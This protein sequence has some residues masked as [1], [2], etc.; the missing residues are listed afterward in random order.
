[1]PSYSG[2]WDGIYLT[3]YAAQS[4]TVAIRDEYVMLARLYARRTYGRGS[5]GKLLL[6]LVGVAPGGTATMTHKRRAAE[7]QIGNPSYSGKAV[8]E[9]FSALNRAT[10][11]GD[12]T[13][14]QA[15]LAL[16]SSPTYAVDRSGNGGGSK[17][18]S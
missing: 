12:V 9:T 13:R 2:L 3:P 7:S 6:A 4:A 10:V 1:M 5:V 14:F 15:A 8:I 18:N 16:Q 11:A 17:L